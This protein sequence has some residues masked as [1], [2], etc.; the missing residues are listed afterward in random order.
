MTCYGPLSAY[1]PA[2]S[3][4]DGPGNGPGSGRLVFDKR[5]SHSGIAVKVPCGKCVGC[6][7]DR[8][9]QWAVRCM[10]EK[11][12]FNASSF[13]T[14]TYDQD[15]LPRSGTLEKAELQLF[16]KR[17]RHE[18]GA[19]LRFF[20]AGEYGSQT[21][22]PHYHVLLFNHDFGDKRFYKASQSGEP[23]Y[24]SAMLTDTWG[25]GECSIG[26]VTFNSCVYVAQYCVKKMDQPRT[27]LLARLGLEPEFVVMSRRPGLGAE[28]WRRYGADTSR[29]DN[30]IMGGKEVKLP[31]F[32]DKKI[33][34]ADPA[35]LAELRRA[36]R[37]RIDK[38]EQT[39]R[40]RYV[41]EQVA[42]ARLKLHSRD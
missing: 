28:W 22:R 37:A 8:A 30:V 21:F 10:H 7:Q 35:R 17:I 36:R 32:Y 5:K 31:R 4:D 42:T 29:H 9:R 13:L 6:Y 12:L 14:L 27:A 41:K 20:A 18:T 25:K 3:K 38:N 26:A 19:G 11:Q 15:N 34:Q 40:R 33:E 23:I 1:Y 16:M 2:R 39:S 24:H